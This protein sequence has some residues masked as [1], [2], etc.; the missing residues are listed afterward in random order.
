MRL[1]RR[2]EDGTISLTSHFDKDHL[3]AYAILSHTWGSDEDEASFE[4]SVNGSWSRRSIG[5]KNIRFCAEQAKADG[6]EYFW[7]DTCCIN[8][9]SSS[10]L[11]EAINSMFDW[12]RK[13]Q[14]CYVYLTDVWACD[15]S[16]IPYPTEQIMARFRRSRWFTRGWTLQELLAPY[17]VEYFSAEC[18]KLGTKQG[19]RQ[20]IIE[21]T[22]LPLSAI[23]GLPLT[24]FS[25]EDRL[26]WGALRTTKR[27]EDAAYSLF[28]IFGISMPLLYGEGKTRAFRRLNVEIKK[29]AQYLPSS[30]VPSGK[31]N[32]NPGTT[33][34]KDDLKPISFPIFCSNSTRRAWA[35]PTTQPAR[36][37]TPQNRELQNKIRSRQ[38]NLRVPKSTAVESIA[39]GEGARVNRSHESE[40]TGGAQDRCPTQSLLSITSG[41]I[42][43]SVDK[44]SGI[45]EGRILVSCN[46]DASELTI[47][48]G[49]RMRTYKPPRALIPAEGDGQ[50]A[51]I[52]RFVYEQLGS[53]FTRNREI[54]LH[55]VVPLMTPDSSKISKRHAAIAAGFSP[56][57]RMLSQVEAAGSPSRIRG[58]QK[59]GCSLPPSPPPSEHPR[60]IPS[61]RPMPSPSCTRDDSTNMLII[62]CND[63]GCEMAAYTLANETGS[64]KEIA[65]SRAVP[66]G[67]NELGISL[68]KWLLQQFGASFS[69]VDPRLI[70]H[71]GAFMNAFERH[72][73]GLA[74]TITN[75]K[76]GRF[77]LSMENVH[78]PAYNLDTGCVVLDRGASVT[79]GAIIR[80]VENV[81]PTSTKALRHYGCIYG[82][83]F[84]EGI[85]PPRKAYTEAYHR[86]EFCDDRVEWLMRKGQ[87]ITPQTVA[88]SKNTHVCSP[89]D[90]TPFGELRFVTCVLQCPPQWSNSPGVEEATG[91]IRTDFTPEEVRQ[92]FTLRN[93]RYGLDSIVK[94]SLG[95]HAGVLQAERVEEK[96]G[97]AMG[98]TTIRFE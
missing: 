45:E 63:S 19:L 47:S 94:L 9:T 21:A 67:W 75:W 7:I 82:M 10:E 77:P 24:Q 90:P 2:A 84:R 32:R 71:N 20:Q 37:Y 88:A 26:S 22:A 70:A 52:K 33:T 18:T 25:V 50:A 51:A 58:N 87:D 89:D 79:V 66:A 44:C 39:E 91:V 55:W 16:D 34:T 12:Y 42:Q 43:R 69:N 83:P 46:Q 27:S 8:K 11:Q 28:G 56:S 36:L 35:V 72:V 17:Q 76:T 73:F 6:L 93:G 38:P 78:H 81:K 92:R 53:E 3:P 31:S 29:E 23:N 98:T 86:M 97:K 15:G 59:P 95:Y 85:D 65:L 30:L 40:T 49:P 14:V 62:L 57:S 61:A 4:D 1:L 5:T 54:A 80:E 41:R 64:H 68:R 60:S 48:C 13:A 74:E 96:I